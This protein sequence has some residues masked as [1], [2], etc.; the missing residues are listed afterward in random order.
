MRAS[1]S[2]MRALPLTFTAS[3]DIPQ[4]A[5]KAFYPM[6]DDSDWAV[7]VATAFR[8]SER[9]FLT[10]S[11]AY[12]R[13]RATLPYFVNHGISSLLALNYRAAGLVVVSIVVV[14]ILIENVSNL[15]RR[16]IL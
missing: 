13:E 4:L 9:Y 16:V 8:L 6:G 5:T 11:V 10:A 3:A 2:A 15:I 12:Q 1:V 14:V 7:G